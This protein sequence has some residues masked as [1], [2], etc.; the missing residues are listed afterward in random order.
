MPENYVHRIGR[1]GRMGKDG[2][3]YLFVCP[4]Q[5]EPLTAIENLTNKM[6]PPLQLEGFTRPD[7][8][9][10]RRPASCSIPRR[11]GRRP[12]RAR[13]ASTIASDLDPPEGL[14]QRSGACPEFAVHRAAR[15][16]SPYRA[17]SHRAVESRPACVPRVSEPVRS[18]HPAALPPASVR[19]RVV[20][21]RAAVVDQ[22]VTHAMRG[23]HP[24][25]ESTGVRGTRVAE[26]PL[27]PM[28]GSTES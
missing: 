20:R 2:I 11:R 13:L 23:D 17:R 22:L 7:R 3:A 10:S 9:S 28:P 5:G 16:W 6:I 15:R 8:E 18:R 27:R 24:R 12:W 26:S 25:T 4:D 1:T 19:P 14:E 21:Y